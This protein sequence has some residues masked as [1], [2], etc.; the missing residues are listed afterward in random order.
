ML[1]SYVIPTRGRPER[2]AAT[3]RALATRTAARAEVV[4]ID[5]AAP[6]PVR[7]P[8]DAAGALPV[9]VVRLE[10]RHGAAARNAGVRVAAGR[11]IVML[12]DDSYPVNDGML[13]R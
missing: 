3:L 1:I 6:E 11:W 10:T 13:L 2:L 8:R 12:D 7:L 9:T 5:D 4:V